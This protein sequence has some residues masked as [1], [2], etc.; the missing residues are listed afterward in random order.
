MTESKAEVFLSV[1]VP[2]YNEELNLP[3]FF[4]RLYPVLDGLGRT[5]EI[6][7]TNDGSIDRSI[8]VLRAQY[9]ARPDVIRVIDFSANYGQHV[10]IIAAFE[11][12]RGE[13][14]VTLDAD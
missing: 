12:V 14:I 6:V 10:A 1:V 4:T 11:R 3:A 13:V 7:F 2:V 9:A 5:Y 8:E